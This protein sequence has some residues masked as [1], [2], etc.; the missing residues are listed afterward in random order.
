ML[1]VEEIK[2][3]LKDRKL[4]V[5]SRRT[6]LTYAQ[7]YGLTTTVAHPAYDVVRALSDYFEAE[8]TPQK[9]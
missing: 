6:G 8:K 9:D 3:L 2:I 4:S 5:I 7:V 1:T